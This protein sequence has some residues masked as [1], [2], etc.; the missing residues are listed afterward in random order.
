MSNSN[1]TNNKRPDSSGSLM[2]LRRGPAPRSRR[3]RTN[4]NRESVWRRALVGLFLL[5]LAIA[6]PHAAAQQVRPLNVLLLND[7]GIGA[8]GINAMHDALVAA[9]DNVVVVAPNGNAS[10]VSASVHLGEVY[11]IQAA[12]I[13]NEFKVLRTTEHLKPLATPVPATP[14]ECLVLSRA[15]THFVPDI[16][17]SGINNGANSGLV[18][19]T[20]GTVAGASVASTRFSPFGGV[21]AI[22]VSLES[23]PTPFPPRAGF[24]QNYDEAAAFVV[25]LIGRIQSHSDNGK[26]LPEG[27]FLNVNYPALAKS[28]IKGVEVTSQGDSVLFNSSAFPAPRAFQGFPLNPSFPSQPCDLSAADGYCLA[29]AVPA[30][31]NET[32]RDADTS[33][34]VDGYISI[35]PFATDYTA[36]GALGGVVQW[37]QSFL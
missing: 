16:V 32:V 10:G 30:D 14:V 22:A 3:N 8:P 1:D 13:T 28:D 2:G 25:N 21:P 34:V 23:A 27:V 4:T 18:A 7:D 6:A 33:A 20:S 36:G 15:V 31:N 5:A 29:G 12:G 26:L 24:T 35:S 37:L 11:L 17:I 19:F 9:G